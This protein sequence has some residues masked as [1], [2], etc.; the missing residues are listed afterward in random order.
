MRWR[1]PENA[2]PMHFSHPLS[3]SGKC[4]PYTRESGQS[5]NLPD[6]FYVY[7]CYADEVRFAGKGDRHFPELIGFRMVQPD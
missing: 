3:A 6:A 7:E 5:P 1:T 4:I 2:C